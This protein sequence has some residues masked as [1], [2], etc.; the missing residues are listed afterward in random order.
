MNEERQ[1]HLTDWE[2]QELARARE[3]G[4]WESAVKWTRNN[5]LTPSMKDQV[6]RLHSRDPE[7]WWARYHMTVGMK[8]RNALR[9]A[10]YSE[11]DFNVENLDS[12]YVHLLEEA[13]GV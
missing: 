10:G 11:D 13:A 8:Y 2:I 1:E 9:A 3:S 6:R 4:L 12:I 5:W 7:R